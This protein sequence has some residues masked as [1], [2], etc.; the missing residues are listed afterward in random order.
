[1]QKISIF[2]KCGI[3]AQFFFLGEIFTIW[4]SSLFVWISHSLMDT[5][6][7]SSTKA[8]PINI[9]K[10]TKFQFRKVLLQFVQKKCCNV[11]FWSFFVKAQFT[12][13][14]KNLVT[15]EQE[16]AYYKNWNPLQETLI[17]VYIPCDQKMLKQQ[18]IRMWTSNVRKK[19]GR[20]ASDSSIK[21]INVWKT[22]Y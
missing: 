19:H 10:K 3:Y 12:I 4:W 11:I 2:G 1:M 18:Q 7:I 9:D 20:W 14:K 8:K 22:A 6:K 17:L 13:I 16:S 5:S 21:T 15:N